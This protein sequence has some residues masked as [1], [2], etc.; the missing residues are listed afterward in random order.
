MITFGAEL[1]QGFLKRFETLAGIGLFR[2]AGFVLRVRRTN[3]LGDIAVEIGNNLFVEFHCI[4]RGDQN[5]GFFD[6]ACLFGLGECLVALGLVFAKLVE[7]ADIFFRP[8]FFIAGGGIG[9]AFGIAEQNR[10][11]AFHGVLF[12]KLG[13][14]LARIFGQLAFL[15]REIDF[16]QHKAVL[17][18]HLECVV[19]ED[20]VIELDAPAAPVG[21]GEVDE[22][23]FFRFARGFLRGIDVG[24]PAFATGEHMTRSVERQHCGAEFDECFHSFPR[25]LSAAATGV[26]KQITECIPATGQAISPPRQGSCPCVSHSPRPD[27]FAARRSRSNGSRDARNKARRP[28]HPGASRSFR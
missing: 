25:T 21:A 18:A 12:S 3:L 9:F 2:K 20:L 16:H 23:V 17:H 27:P 15:A 22:Q 24:E 11:V 7:M 28:Q 5:L 4:E 6:A 14:P 19:L 1:L 13:V 8:A 26:E 10:R